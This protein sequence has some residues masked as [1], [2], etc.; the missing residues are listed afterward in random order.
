M[1]QKMITASSQQLRNTS[2]TSITVW[3]SF[4]VI[5]PSPMTRALLLLYPIGWI[6]FRHV[7]CFSFFFLVWKV[8]FA[9]VYKC[10]ILTFGEVLKLSMYIFCIVHISFLIKNLRKQLVYKPPSFINSY[11]IIGFFLGRPFCSVRE[12]IFSWNYTFAFKV[13]CKTCS[14]YLAIHRKMPW[15]S[16]DYLFCACNNNSIY[17]IDQPVLLSSHSEV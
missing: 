5:K 9:L 16:S 8:N 13:R 11:L 17:F 4:S 15:E 3:M 6:T 2:E 10:I 1:T 7:S 12:F 14:P